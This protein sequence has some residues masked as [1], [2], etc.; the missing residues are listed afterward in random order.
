MGHQRPTA[1]SPLKRSAKKSNGK[2]TSLLHRLTT[3]IALQAVLCMGLHADEPDLSKARSIQKV[4]SLTAELINGTLIGLGSEVTKPVFYAF[5]VAVGDP[6]PLT[7]ADR[8]KLSIARLKQTRVSEEEVGKMP[9]LEAMDYYVILDDRRKV[10]CL[11]AKHGGQR[12]S[13][14]SIIEAGS[15]VFQNDPTGDIDAY[16]DLLFPQ[17][18]ARY[19]KQAEQGS[20]H[21]S[22][23][24]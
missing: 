24:R 15:Q 6:I 22:T 16:Y 20:A 10:M 3:F 17:T 14:S 11:L 4:K 13:L 21:Q 9:M 18:K 7:E 1:V 12:I 8:K 23:T 19:Q 5:Y 2:M